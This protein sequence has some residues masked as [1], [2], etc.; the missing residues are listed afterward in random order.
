MSGHGRGRGGRHAD[1][2]KRAVQRAGA[3]LL[4][5]GHMWAR[6]V[7]VAQR[8]L[9]RAVDAGADEDVVAE[10]RRAVL[11]ARSDDA[12]L[13]AALDALELQV[14]ASP[15]PDAPW[16]QGARVEVERVRAGLEGRPDPTGGAPGVRRGWRD[17]PPVITAAIVAWVAIAVVIAAAVIRG[18]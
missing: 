10:R 9:K 7:S 13:R 8:A 17:L 16:A 1:G 2:S 4:N 6:K 15:E 18:L 5:E 14:N 12:K 3:D 11:L